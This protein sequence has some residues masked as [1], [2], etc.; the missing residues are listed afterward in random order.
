[1]HRQTKGY[2][3]PWNRQRR[4]AREHLARVRLRA[5]ADA[6]AT[7]EVR[8][9]LHVVGGP[10]DIDQAQQAQKRER[11]QR[12]V[13]EPRVL[14]APLVAGKRARLPVLQIGDD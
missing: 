3:L 2:R 1:M 10:V 11:V 6:V 5:G 12:A 14:L 7:V 4:Q 9:R 13:Q 8:A